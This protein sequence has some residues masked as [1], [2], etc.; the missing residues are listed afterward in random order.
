MSRQHKIILNAFDIPTRPEH[1]K[2]MEPILMYLKHHRRF[3][4]LLTSTLFAFFTS[5]VALAQ[6]SPSSCGQ[7]RAPGQFGPFDFRTAQSQLPIVENYHFTP[8]V[9][10]LIRGST[11]TLPGGDLD[12]T[13]RAFPNHHRALSAVVRYGDKMK[14][15][16]P[17][18]LNFSV[19]CY[20]YR[21]LQFRPDDTIV[22][23]IYARYLAKLERTPEAKQQLELATASAGDNAFSHYNIGLIYFDF[24]DFDKALEQAHK[25]IKL[26]FPRTALQ[27]QLQSIGKWAESAA[28]QPD[29]PTQPV[30]SSTPKA[31]Q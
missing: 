5:T 19:E 7:L 28:A 26:G 29:S 24:K 16:K 23:M 6:V 25:A 8:V 30:G 3:C 13:L 11:N 20:F 17:P 1:K 27:E 4:F 15:L 22:R 12:Y 10:A 14:S 21:A 9:E 18:G 31:S 2:Q